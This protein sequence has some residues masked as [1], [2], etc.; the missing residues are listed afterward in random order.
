MHSVSAYQKQHF[1][2]LG[3]TVPQAIVADEWKSRLPGLDR[4]WSMTKGRPEVRIAVLDGPIDEGA[5]ARSHVVQS[6]VVEHATLVQ[7]IIAGSTD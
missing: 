7:S 4:L 5:V 2:R 3:R 1:S 6:G